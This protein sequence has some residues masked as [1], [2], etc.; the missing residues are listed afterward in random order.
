[1]AMS[2]RDSAL[3]EEVRRRTVWSS[4]PPNDA[5]HWPSKKRRVLRSLNF[6]SCAYLACQPV[7]QIAPPQGL[8]ECVLEPPGGVVV[9]IRVTPHLQGQHVF[10]GL[11]EEVYG[12]ERGGV[13]QLGGLGE[14]AGKQAE[15]ALAVVAP[16]C[17]S[18]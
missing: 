16:L 7:A 1:M 15:L 12:E 5:T 18:E 3:S 17:Q 13:G 14:G 2:R 10:L 8:R 11:G 6:G 4:N 9:K